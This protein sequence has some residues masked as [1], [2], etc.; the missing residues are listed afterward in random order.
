MAHRCLAIQFA[1]LAIAAASA[2]PARADIAT[3]PEPCSVADTQQAG[4]QC[5]A[6]LN[7]SVDCHKEYGQTGYSQRCVAQDGTA[8]EVWCKADTSDAGGATDAGTRTPP[9]TTDHAAAKDEGGGC[10]LGPG[11]RAG[12]WSTAVLGLLVV[13]L[14]GGRKRRPA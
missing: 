3:D 12:F 8:L 7:T 2:A 6:C 4:E 1:L 13:A 11:P 10:T 9:S 5:V 14:R